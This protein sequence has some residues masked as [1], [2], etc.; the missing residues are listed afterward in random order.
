MATDERSE[1]DDAEDRP[2]PLWDVEAGAPERLYECLHC[3]WTARLADN[4]TTCPECDRTVR[5][6]SMPI[7]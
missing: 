1:A 2:D 3:G 7:E 5:N 6:C 4:P